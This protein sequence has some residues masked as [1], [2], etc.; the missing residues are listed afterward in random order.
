MKVLGSYEDQGYE[1]ARK[2][3]IKMAENELKMNRTLLALHGIVAAM[4]W[5]VFKSVQLIKLLNH[6]K[7][8]V[9]V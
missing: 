2:L 3:I 8:E 5:N 4:Q 9:E 1:G 7:L 6:S